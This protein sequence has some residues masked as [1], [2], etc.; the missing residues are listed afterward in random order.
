MR[1]HHCLTPAGKKTPDARGCRIVISHNVGPQAVCIFLALTGLL[2]LRKIHRGH[3]SGVKLAFW[4]QVNVF[5]L[6][7]V[8]SFA[9]SPP[10]ITGSCPVLVVRS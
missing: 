7:C 5:L 2:W 6:M 10:P 3:C 1:F 4:L 8:P 9:L